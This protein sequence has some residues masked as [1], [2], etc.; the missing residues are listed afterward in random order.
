MKTPL[1]FYKNQI[2]VLEKEAD[3]HQ[4][5]SVFF[6]ILRFFIFLVTCF[7]VYYYFGEFPT[8]IIC[9]FLGILFFIFIV[10]KQLKVKRLHKITIEKLRINKLEIE[11]LNGNFYQLPTGK[12]FSDSLHFY[13]NDI[14]LFGKGSFFQYINRT[15]TIKGKQVLANIITE[16]TTELIIEKQEVV[17]ELSKKVAFRQHFAALAGIE[18]GATDDYNISD[19]IQNYTLTLPKYISKIQLL[20]STISIILI[21]SVSLKLMAFNWL[22]IWF[23][24]GLF[25]TAKFVKK[26]NTIYTETN[27]AKATFKQYH[28]LLHEIETAF[29][30]S[31]ILKEKQQ[32]IN[33]NTQKASA[34]FKKFSR[35]LDNF[36]QRN[37]IIIAI[38]GNGLFLTDIYH[39][40][41][42]EK[43]LLSHKNTVKEWFEVVAFFDAQNSLANLYFNKPSYTFPIISSE[44]NSVSAEKLG[45]PLLN[46]SKRID[47]N[48]TI[49]KGHFFIITGANM[50][51]K[52]TF[53]R[54]VSL[55]IVMANCGLPVCAKSFYYHPTKLITSMRTSDSL[56]EDTS[57]FYSELKRLKFIVN[58][59]KN[60]DFFIILDEIL[61]GT[62]SKDKAIGSKK[63]VEKLNTSKSTGIIATHDVSLCDLEKD[64]STIKNYYFD[65]EINNNEL[66][67]DYILKDG[68]CKN[69]NASFLLEKMEII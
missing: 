34:I 26:T 49:Q 10:I 67:F 56:S 55:A 43:W 68:I 45:H 61:K 32:T 15:S 39:S 22:V 59:I 51:G 62:N 4:R 23:F 25:T 40:H 7:S 1:E 20:F 13:S 50:A 54:T 18:K 57:Y 36:D 8:I 31:K 58:T 41:K 60:E 14:D 66:H 52:S 42:V 5:T 12:E 21:V 37:N 35:I 64:F 24:L 30:R 11:V 63:F 6:S 17:K 19:W 33:S 48:F 46:N 9:A 16:N 2:N 27:L 44:K 3:K 65:A 29:F 28:P 47:N 53:L 38:T 69:M